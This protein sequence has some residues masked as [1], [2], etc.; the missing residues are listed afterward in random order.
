MTY[1]NEYT[2]QD[3]KRDQD[4]WEHANEEYVAEPPQPRS[5]PYEVAARLKKIAVIA[6]YLTACGFGSDD[7]ELMD[8]HMW[9]EACRGAK[10]KSASAAT[11]SGVIESMKRRA[12]R[13]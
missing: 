1:D 6:N 4:A 3:S 13:S 10:V 2:E 11:R 9:A 7:V 5:N 12:V 8:D